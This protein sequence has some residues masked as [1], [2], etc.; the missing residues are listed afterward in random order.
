MNISVMYWS[1]EISMASNS[2]VEFIC[3]KVRIDTSTCI[4][5]NIQVI[6]C[7]DFLQLPPVANEL[8]GDFGHFCFESYMVPEVFCTQNT[9][10][11]YTQI[12]QLRTNFSC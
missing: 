9:L 12:G 2:Q 1:D 8:H 5:G 3:Q 4:F 10:K 11:Y 6:L 7:G